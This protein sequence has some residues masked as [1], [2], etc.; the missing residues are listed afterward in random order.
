MRVLKWKVGGLLDSF[1]LRRRAS[2]AELASASAAQWM[3]GPFFLLVIG[4]TS[5]LKLQE[6][7]CFELENNHTV[8]VAEVGVEYAVSAR[9][10]RVEVEVP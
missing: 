10:D 2:L 1:L 5:S 3:E 6:I 4:R 7:V 8:L 9:G